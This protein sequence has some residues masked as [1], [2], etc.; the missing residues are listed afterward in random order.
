[1]THEVKSGDF[2]LFLVQHIPLSSKKGPDLT[3]LCDNM[4]CWGDMKRQ[5]TKVQLFLSHLSRAIVVI[6]H[7]LTRSYQ[8]Y[9]LSLTLIGFSK[10]QS[11]LAVS[12]LNPF[13]DNQTNVLITF[14]LYLKKWDK[15]RK[16]LSSTL[17]LQLVY[18]QSRKKGGRQHTKQG[19]PDA[20]HMD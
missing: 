3:F 9:L 10:T 5:G 11:C 18:K 14:M 13:G 19:C 6:L 15:V 7:I 2:S 17:H 4:L 1:M 12:L 8:C 20:L 16:V